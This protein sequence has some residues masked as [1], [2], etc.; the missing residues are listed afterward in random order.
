MMCTRDKILRAAREAF[1]E[2]GFDG[3]SVDEIAK[4]AGVKKALIYYYFPS[5]EE[6][7]KEVWEGALSELEEHLFRQIEGESNYVAKLKKFLRSYIDFVTNKKVISRVIEREKASVM[8][9]EKWEDLR[10]RYEGFLGRIADLIAEG[11]RYNA[12]YEDIDPWAAADLISGSINP[13][14]KAGILEKIISVIVRG[15]AKE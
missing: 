11:K 7:F 14:K 8:S 2:K 6:L 3:V 15:I 5:K 4:R 12:V 9:S 1:A 10:K 13:S